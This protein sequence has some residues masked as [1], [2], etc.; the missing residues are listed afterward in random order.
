MRRSQI[1]S[2]WVGLPDQVVRAFDRHLAG[3]E[4][5]GAL[6][7]GLAEPGLADA[8]GAGQEQVATLGNPGAGDEGVDEGLV[9]TAPGAV[10]V[11]V[12]EHGLAAEVGLA[13]A[14][15]ELALCSRWVHSASTSR[16]RRSPKLSAVNS[17]LPS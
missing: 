15:P 13:Q 9:E 3:D 12:L 1:A 11:D 7:E 10:P 4:G 8:G 2:A 5:R 6:G 14:A 17:G 16:P